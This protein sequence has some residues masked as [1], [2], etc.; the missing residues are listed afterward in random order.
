MLTSS[1]Y[2]SRS[3][4][5]HLFLIS[6]TPLLLLFTRFN[7]VFALTIWTALLIWLLVL[8]APLLR[9]HKLLLLGCV[10]TITMIVLYRFVSIC[11]FLDCQPVPWSEQ[12][13]TTHQEIAYYGSDFVPYKIQAAPDTLNPLRGDRPV[14]WRLSFLFIRLTPD[15]KPTDSPYQIHT[16]DIN[17]RDPKRTISFSPGSAWI[18]PVSLQ[19]R[20]QAFE[21]VVISPRQAV[22]QVRQDRLQE[23]LQPI[24]DDDLLVE[25]LLDDAVPRE[26]HV[27]A[28]WRVSTKY[29]TDDAVPIYWID[30]NSGKIV[31]HQESL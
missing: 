16:I 22:E 26:I 23:H 17:D 6:G 4:I 29:Y 19:Q 20:A 2:T 18:D 12:V 5:L 3:R 28:V 1:T 24:N 30:A 11:L 27:P 8:Q 10:S 7:P 21:T 31:K 9:R 15:P 13:A 25:L 14:N